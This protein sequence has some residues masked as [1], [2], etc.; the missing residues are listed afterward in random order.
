MQIV[1]TH[2]GLPTVK[3]SNRASQLIDVLVDLPMDLL[4]RP[5]ELLIKSQVASNAHI[6]DTA[7]HS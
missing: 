3:T 7:E 2:L 6:S 1:I 5:T 4:R